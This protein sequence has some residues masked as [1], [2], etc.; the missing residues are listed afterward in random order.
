M[1]LAREAGVSIGMNARQCLLAWELP[2]HINEIITSNG[3]HQQW[4]YGTHK[5][6]YFDNG[7]LTAIQE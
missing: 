5:Y 6:L 3:K 4:V 7:I 2:E 1:R